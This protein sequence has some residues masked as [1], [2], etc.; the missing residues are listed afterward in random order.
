VRS[1][2]TGDHR[3]PTEEAF[4]SSPTV[5]YDVD[6][7]AVYIRLSHEEVSE[8]VEISESLYI[9]VDADGSPV[10]IEILG[11]DAEGLVD[12]PLVQTETEL[13]ALLKGHAA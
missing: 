1:R 7:E 11:V 6:A 13:R 8:T 12:M 2:R 4:I 5:Q 9:D 10:G 3:V